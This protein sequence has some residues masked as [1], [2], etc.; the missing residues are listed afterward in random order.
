MA[1]SG[2][3]CD[4]CN[5]GV[6]I[7]VSFQVCVAKKDILSRLSVCVVCVNEG[8]LRNYVSLALEEFPGKG[9]PIPGTLHTGTCR[10][11]QSEERTVRK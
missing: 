10:R 1:L 11:S 9:K 5:G 4:L 8:D 7:I 2:I 3:D 6:C